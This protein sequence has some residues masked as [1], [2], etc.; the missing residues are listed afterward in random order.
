MAS[1]VEIANRALTKLGAARII[2]FGDDNKQA[3]AVQSMFAIVRDAELRAHIWSFS[4]KRASL[5]ALTSTPDW[6]FEYEYE[7]PSDCLRLIQVNDFYQGPSMD[8]YR[9]QSTA[10][11]I[12]EGNKILTD[13]AA[14]L[15]IRYIKREEDTA[16]WDAT[17]VEA[18]ACRLAAEMAED[19][20]QSNQKKDAAWKEYQQALSLAIRSGAVEQQP[21]DMP[22]DSWMLSRI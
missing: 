19:L 17:F 1:Q 10:E 2:S 11:Y 14:P 13:Y 6:G 22:D 21:Q 8:D 3:R 9:N 15:K 16:Q 12:L 5:A 20:T 7:L 4:L 18:F